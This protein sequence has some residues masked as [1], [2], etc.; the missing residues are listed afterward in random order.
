MIPLP[1]RVPYLEFRDRC[2]LRAGLARVPVEAISTAS[3]LMIAEAV[4]PLMCLEA[5]GALRKV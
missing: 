2:C 1:Q 4:Y 3:V 5:F